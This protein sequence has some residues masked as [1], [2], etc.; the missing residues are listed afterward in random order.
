MDT[1]TVTKADL[2]ATLRENRDAHQE[3]FD[4]AQV[5]YREKMIEELDRAL[6]EARNGGKIRRGFSL[7]V[8]ENHVED[9]DTAIQMLEW[10]TGDTVDLTMREFRQYV[11][12][13]WGWQASYAANTLSYSAM[14]DEQAESI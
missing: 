12:N 9:F 1:I 5:V 11:Q 7:P 14:L 13:E 2:I 3:V 4:K 8:P 6:E 10:D